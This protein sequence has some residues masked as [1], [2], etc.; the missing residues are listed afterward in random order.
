MFFGESS[1]SMFKDAAKGR[2]EATCQWCYEHVQ[3][4]VVGKSLVWVCCN[5]KGVCEACEKCGQPV[6]SAMVRKDNFKTC[7]MCFKKDW[8]K[9]EKLKNDYVVRPRKLQVLQ[10][11]L[12]KIS[13]FRENAA[14][15]G[16]LRPFL[17]LVSLPS[18]SRLQI[19]INLGFTFV[20]STFMGDAHAESWEIIGRRDLGLRDRM[21]RLR[22]TFFRREVNW[23]SILMPPCEELCVPAY[24]NWAEEFVCPQMTYAEA[25]K[26]CHADSSSNLNAL[27]NEFVDKMGKHQRAR[28]SSL[29]AC[30]LAELKNSE[31]IRKLLAMPQLQTQGV[32]ALVSYAIDTSF[33]MLAR[34]DGSDGTGAVESIDLVQEVVAFFEG[35]CEGEGNLF[36][37]ATAQATTKI[38]RDGVEA[39]RDVPPPGSILNANISGFWLTMDLLDI[40]NQTPSGK[41]LPVLLQMLF[42]KGRLAI[43]GIRVEDYIKD[44]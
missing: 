36:A 20:G 8:K 9:M 21:S 44:F 11:D 13:E 23:Y 33:M 41:I 37:D 35:V 26:E 39:G 4:F 31:P 15:G 6:R 42:H 27:E 17:F 30:C 19:A 25:L 34:R 10:K 28:M 3:M 18:V 2:R 5:C 1:G 22:D 29:Q 32:Q 16:T 38:S 14:K 7:S 40:D 12:E 43:H 24:M